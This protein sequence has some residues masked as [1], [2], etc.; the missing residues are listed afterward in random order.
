[1]KFTHAIKTS[2]RLSLASWDSTQPWL[3]SVTL[4][5]A[6]GLYDTVAARDLAVPPLTLE[7]FSLQHWSF[8]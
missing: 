1:M 2:L 6:L 5:Y 7:Y 3:G 8:R 4:A